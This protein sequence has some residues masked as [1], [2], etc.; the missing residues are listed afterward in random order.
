VFNKNLA[1]D[2]S[3]LKSKKHITENKIKKTIANKKILSWFS[4]LNLHPVPKQ[5]LFEIFIYL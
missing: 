4:P 3:N 5:K 2:V 1:R